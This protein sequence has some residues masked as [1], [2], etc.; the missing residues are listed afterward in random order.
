MSLRPACRWQRSRGKKFLFGVAFSLPFFAGCFTRIPATEL[1]A[2]PEKTEAVEAAR[3]E[4]QSSSR[5]TKR[6]SPDAL[7]EEVDAWTYV[8]GKPGELRRDLSL[9]NTS[10]EKLLGAGLLA[11][12]IG[13][14]SNLWGQTEFLFRVVPAAAEKA[15]ELRLDSIYAVDGLKAYYEEQYQ[16]RFPSTWL[17]DQRVA[18]LKAGQMSSDD[19]LGMSRR[20]RPGA[21]PQGVGPDAAWGPAGGGDRGLKSRENLSVVKQTLPPKAPGQPQQISEILGDPEASL[22][23]LLK[24]TIAPEGAKKTA[25]ALNAIKVERAGNIYYEYQ[26]RTTFPSGAKLRSFSSCALGPADRR[27]NRN[28]Y[29]LTAVLPE[30]EVVDGQGAAPL[31]AEIMEGAVLIQMPVGYSHLLVSVDDIRIIQR[32]AASAFPIDQPQT[33]STS[34]I[35]VLLNP[36]VLDSDNMLEAC[37]PFSGEAAKELC[38]S[39]VWA[40]ATIAAGGNI[41]TVSLCS[42]VYCDNARHAS[43][44]T[45]F[46]FSGFEIGDLPTLL[47]P[48]VSASSQRLWPWL[49]LAMSF[50][51]NTANSKVRIIASAAMPGEAVQTR[52]SHHAEHQYEGFLKGLGATSQDVI[53]SK[54]ASQLKRLHEATH[55]AIGCQKWDEG[56][57]GASVTH[58]TFVDP[59]VVYAT[60]DAP[61]KNMSVVELRQQAFKPEIHYRTEQRDRFEDPGPQPKN[62]TL[63]PVVSVHFGDD[64]PGFSLQSH[65]AH[66]KIAQEHQHQKVLR[67]AGSGVLIPT[68]AWP[69]PV[70]CNPVTGGPRNADVYDLGVAAGV[71][72]DRVSQ[73]SSTI[74]HEAHVRNPIHG[75]AIPLHAYANPRGELGRS[76]EQVVA[77]ANRMV[78]ALR[79]LAAVR[80]H[81]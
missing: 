58:T 44:I 57:R 56:N 43:V 21:A 8:F 4:G 42:G 78:P 24:E 48:A 10:P 81:C 53:C 63:V 77:E 20:A 32:G 7:A 64:R 1:R 39:R 6:S 67:A 38:K 72:H 22:E 66:R 70:R 74:V 45:S 35:T 73:N 30:S 49:V 26:W 28:L 5:K 60:S 79:S 16:A 50:C 23:R 17:F 2:R 31:I 25:E 29:T 18:L 69:K 61:D 55:F 75:I 62:D 46:A 41:W 51:V 15:R 80:P 65:S 37:F 36:G 76:S 47:R 13:L 34:S 3:P 54:K 71:R 33:R 68:S 11:V 59:E 9:V 52:P 19:M 12:V 40:E 27:G 14:A